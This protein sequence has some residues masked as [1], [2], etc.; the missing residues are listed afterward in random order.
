MTRRSLKWFCD[1]LHDIADF[2][3]RDRRAK[4]SS[5]DNTERRRRDDD[6]RDTKEAS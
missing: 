1:I 3:R 5:E 2:F 6:S 4:D